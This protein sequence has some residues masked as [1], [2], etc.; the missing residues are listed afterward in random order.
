MADTGPRGPAGTSLDLPVAIANGGTGATTA[1]AAAN[2]LKVPTLGQR[3][4]IPSNADLD[5]YSAV[6]GYCCISNTDA[7]SLVNCPTS[8]AFIMDVGLAQGG[9]GYIS[10]AVREHYTGTLYYRCLTTSSGEWGPWYEFSGT[11]I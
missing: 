11:R 6:G 8:G 4:A 2:A 9:G 5:E 3:S 10:Q 1:Q 7:Q